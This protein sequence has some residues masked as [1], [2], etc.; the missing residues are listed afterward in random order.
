MDYIWGGISAALRDMT[1]S[2]C[3]LSSKNRKYS[4]AHRRVLSLS[5]FKFLC[6]LSRSVL[7]A[8]GPSVGVHHTPAQTQG[9]AGGGMAAQDTAPILYRGGVLRRMLSHPFFA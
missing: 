7:I 4:F 2:T 8:L 9:V 1:L 5:P 6:D 3:R